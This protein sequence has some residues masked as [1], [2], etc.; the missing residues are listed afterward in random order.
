MAVIKFHGTN[1]PTKIPKQE[2][3][4]RACQSNKDQVHSKML[5]VSQFE[6]IRLIISNELNNE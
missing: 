5:V 6:M 2:D 3:S 4:E 1:E